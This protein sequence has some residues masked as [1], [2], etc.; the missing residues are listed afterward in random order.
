MDSYDFNK[1]HKTVSMKPV[2]L[3]CILRMSKSQLAENGFK[4]SVIETI[5]QLILESAA[6]ES[7]MVYFPDVYIPCLIQV[8]EKQNRI[9]YDN[10]F[11]L[12]WKINEILFLAKNVSEEMSRSELLPKV[13]AAFGQ[14]RRKQKIH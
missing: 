13:Q 6:N 4:D 11:V 3:T 14:N 12:I 7:H 2:P 9:L 5:Y 1:K 10:I 8:C